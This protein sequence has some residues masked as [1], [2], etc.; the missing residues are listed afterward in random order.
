[1]TLPAT[2]RDLFL[3]TGRPLEEVLDLQPLEPLAHYR[4]P[5]GTEDGPAQQR[6]HGIAQAFQDALGGAAGNELDALPRASR[7]HLVDRA[8]SV[9]R[10]G[11]RAARRAWSSLASAQAGRHDAHRT[12]ADLARRRPRIVR[13]IRG[14]VLFLDRYATY[15]GSD[16]RRAPA[17]LSVVPYVEHTF[18]GW[19]VAG[20]LRRSRMRSRDARSNSEGTD[21]H[22]E[23]RSVAISASTRTRRRGRALTEEP[24][25]RRRRRQ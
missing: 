24:P 23:P 16:P 6:R 20:G 18:R 8:D 19:H 2:L 4:F 22:R 17:V 7:A 9:R 11:S 1:M 14:S 21:R 12:V 3:K 10:I 13:P 25:R 5:D 15:T